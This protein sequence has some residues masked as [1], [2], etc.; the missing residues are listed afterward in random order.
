[1]FDSP[2]SKFHIDKKRDHG[3]V[4]RLL[5]SAIHPSLWDQLKYLKSKFRIFWI[6]LSI[7]L[8]VT[9]NPVL[10]ILGLVFSSIPYIK[11]GFRSEINRESEMVSNL[12]KDLKRQNKI[13]DNLHSTFKKLVAKTPEVRSEKNEGEK[14]R[15]ALNKLILLKF[16]RY[17]LEHLATITNRN[18][19]SI[20]ERDLINTAMKNWRN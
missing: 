4:K 14:G 3:I 11:N 10:G 2:D 1:M 18:E 8:A 13:S 19:R 9:V 6:F 15:P 5:Y 17:S 7:I 16:E 12:S 20:I